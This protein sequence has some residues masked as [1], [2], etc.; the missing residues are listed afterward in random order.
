MVAKQKMRF[1]VIIPS[2][3][4]LWFFQNNPKQPAGTLRVS[5]IAW[6][7]LMKRLGYKR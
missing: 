1:D 6:I 7:T 5:R 4:E 2:L 3:P